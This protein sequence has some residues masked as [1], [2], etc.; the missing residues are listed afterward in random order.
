MA[1][2]QRGQFHRALKPHTHQLL[3][4]KDC[5]VAEAFSLGDKSKL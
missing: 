3:V 4:V 2:E 1:D 5:Y